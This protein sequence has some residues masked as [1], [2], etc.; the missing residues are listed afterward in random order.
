MGKSR[1]LAIVTVAYVL[2]VAAAAAWLIWGPS[3][4]RLW[5]DT[6]IADVI[7][8]LVVFGFSRA[9]RNSSFYDAY[10]SVIP[11]LLVGVAI[12][13][14]LGLLRVDGLTLQL[15]KPI[16]TTPTFSFAAVIGIV[17]LNVLTAA[18]VAGLALV[19]A[20]LPTAWA[21]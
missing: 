4:G 21:G 14:A 12:A 10:W 9:Y 15:A 6:F 13:G 20:P 7:A 3:T 1:S 8:T 16:F 17:T 2:A 18:L 5:L 11:P 19:A